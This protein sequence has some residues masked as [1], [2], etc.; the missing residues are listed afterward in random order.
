M[1]SPAPVAG[2]VE[3]GFFRCKQAAKAGLNAAGYKSARSGR[4]A[5]VDVQ[6]QNCSLTRV[7]EIENYFGNCLRREFPNSNGRRTSLTGAGGQSGNGY[8]VAIIG[9]RQPA[10]RRD[11]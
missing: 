1:F 4:I 6:Q 3:P 9:E 2:R 8:G 10:T 5:G 7:S 11:M